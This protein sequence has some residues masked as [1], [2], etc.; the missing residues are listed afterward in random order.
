MSTYDAK[1]LQGI[2]DAL[3]HSAPSSAPWFQVI[4]RAVTTLLVCEIERLNN[5]RAAA[6]PMTEGFEPYPEGYRGS[7]TGR[8][9]TQE[10][11]DKVG[12]GCGTVTQMPQ[13][14]AETYAANPGY[15]GSTFCCGCG[16]YLPVGSTGE[17][18]WDGTNERVGT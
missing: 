10:Q 9:W 1:N 8:F 5:P 4:D 14:I 6:E 16:T 12:K 18:V 11:L 7:A 3:N 13:A 2:M 17:F 15:Y